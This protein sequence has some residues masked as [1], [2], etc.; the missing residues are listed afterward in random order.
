MAL[1]YKILKKRQRTKD[2][3]NVK[4][5]IIVDFDDKETDCKKEE[6]FKNDIFYIF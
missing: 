3:Y 4:H 6:L 1:Q 2:I 5:I